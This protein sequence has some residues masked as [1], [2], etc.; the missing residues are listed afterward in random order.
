MASPYWDLATLCNAARL[1]SVQAAEFLHSY[2]A[3]AP[4][5]EESTLCDYRC[6]LQLLSDCWMN[7]FVPETTQS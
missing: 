1:S 2:C 3:D 5:M 6:L 7:A 4:G